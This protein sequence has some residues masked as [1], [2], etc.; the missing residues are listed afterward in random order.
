MQED[1]VLVD[2]NGEV[3]GKEEKRV[4]SGEPATGPWQARNCGFCDGRGF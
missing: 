1:V 4:R 2:A 3:A